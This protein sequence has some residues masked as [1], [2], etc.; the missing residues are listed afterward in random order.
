MP[1]GESDVSDEQAASAARAAMLASERAES[2]MRCAP[3]G[4]VERDHT[5]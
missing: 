5:I 1:V 4:L 2:D 3:G